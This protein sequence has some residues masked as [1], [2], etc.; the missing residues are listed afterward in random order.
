MLMNNN[1]YIEIMPRFS[2]QV[3]ICQSTPTGGQDPKD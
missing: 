1:E 2:A 3:M